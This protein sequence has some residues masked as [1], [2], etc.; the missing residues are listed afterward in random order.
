MSAVSAILDAANIAYTPAAGGRRSYRFSRVEEAR[1]AWLARGDGGDVRAVIDASALRGLAD[2]PRADLARREG[3]L[4]VATGDA[5]DPI[6]EL[7]E[8]FGA[9]VVSKDNFVH[10]RDD[11]PWLQ[12]CSDRVY[13]PSWRGGELVLRPRLLRV[14]SPEDIERARRAKARKAGIRDG[15]GD[16]VWHCA[17]PPD[18]CDLSGT[19]VP[20]ALL[21]ERGGGWYCKCGY[22][23]L[24]QFAGLPT[25]EVTGPPTCA[26]MHGVLLRWNVA[27][28][29]RPRVFGRGGPR[30]P[31]VFDVTAGLSP[32]QA[33]DISR[34]HL[35]VFLDDDGDAIVRHLRPENVTFLN[36]AFGADGL[37]LDNRLADGAEYLLSEDDTLVL[38]SGYVT[39]VVTVPRAEAS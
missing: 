25:L 9:A 36:P 22:P 16:R 31:H 29:R 35:E 27:V 11:H 3:W 21:R 18:E 2:G 5:D 15:L 38:G 8:R 14:A 26:V 1:D 4:E 19:G 6:L 34:K 10:A 24:E 33:K 20:Q 12:G 32:E 28:E 37:P 23:A 7:A 13:S 30:R 39:I 17:A